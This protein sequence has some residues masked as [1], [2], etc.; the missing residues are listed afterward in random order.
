MKTQVIVKF[1]TTP[2]KTSTPGYIDPLNTPKMSTNANS[3]FS[4]QNTETDDVVQGDDTVDNSY[5]SR[6]N[7]PVPVIK[8]EKPVGQPNDRRNPDSDEALGK[9]S[10]WLICI[11]H[12]PF[13][14]PPCYKSKAT[15]REFLLILIWWTEQDEIE[16]IDK[17]NI[18]KGNR[19]RHAKPT[20]T[21]K[22][23]SDEQGLPKAVLDGTNG[24]SSTRWAVP[25][26]EGVG[27]QL[28]RGDLCNFEREM[29][30]NLLSSKCKVCYDRLVEISELTYFCASICCSTL[31]LL[32]SESLQLF[33]SFDPKSI[34][35]PGPAYARTF[36]FKS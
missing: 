25:G 31:S 12:Q 8:D 20:S 10:M 34:V 11:G 2:V 23:P 36:L 7:E 3:E 14:V 6:G 17:S 24:M 19:T 5:A 22:E 13:S 16:A 1:S 28:V 21:Y 35:W 30:R 27:A 29:E 15:K 32:I 33:P 18:L 9:Y 4:N 26:Q